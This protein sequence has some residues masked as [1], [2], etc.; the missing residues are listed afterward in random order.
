MAY[1]PYKPK[2]SGGGAT[3]TTAPKPS[4]GGYDPYAGVGSKSSGGSTSSGSSSGSSKQQPPSAALRNAIGAG[5]V[6]KVRRIAKKRGITGRDLKGLLAVTKFA[7]PDTS[8]LGRFSSDV[9][10]T[11]ENLPRG[12]AGTAKAAGMEALSLPRLVRDVSE[13]KNVSVDQVLGSIPGLGQAYGVSRGFIEEKPSDTNP[14][15][16]GIGASFRHTTDRITDP[17]QA[18]REYSQHPFS[19]AMEDAGNVAVAAGVGARAARLAGLEKTANFLETGSRT[20]DTV[21]QGPFLPVSPLARGANKVIGK[22]VGKIDD[23]ERLHNALAAMHQSRAAREAKAILSERVDRT[24]QA[25]NTYVKTYIK[26]VQKILPTQ[27][28]QDALYAVGKHWDQSLAVERRASPDTFDQYV[29]DHAK[30]YDNISVKAAHM[31]ADVFEGKAPKLAAKIDK[32]MPILVKASKEHEAAQ[33]ASGMNPEQLGYKPL[34]PVVEGAT[35]P[36]DAAAQAKAEV[37][38]QIRARADTAGARAGAVADAGAARLDRQREMTTIGEFG[39]PL[40]NVRRAE[41][42]IGGPITGRDINAERAVA[43]AGMSEAGRAAS[44]QTRADMLNTRANAAERGATR[45]FDKAASVRAQ[46]EASVEA[47]PARLRPV[48]E[49]NQAAISHLTGVENALRGQGLHD[50]AMLVGQAA[51]ELPST[52]AALEEAGIDAPHFIRTVAEPKRGPR[53]VMGSTTPVKEVRQRTGKGQATQSVLLQGKALAA[54]AGQVI[55]NETIAKLESSEFAKMAGEVLPGQTSMLRPPRLEEL[56]AAG[57]APLK[58]AEA[59]TSNTIVVPKEVKAVFDNYYKKAGPF[60]K[61]LEYAYD[62]LTRAFKI[63]VLPLSP[64]WQVGNAIGNT[65]MA[66]FGAGVGPVALSK[67]IIQSIAEYK[68]T[69]EFPGPERLRTHGAS[70]ESQEVM[71]GG[72]TVTKAPRAR[73]ALRK[74][75]PIRAGYGMNEFIDNLGRSAVYLSKKSKGYSDEMATKLTLRAMGDFQKL[76][77]FEKR[78]VRR[79]LPFYAW[80][81]HL[82]K[83]A[84]TMPIEHPLRT[85]FTL[86]LGNMFSTKEDWEGLLPGYLKGSVPFGP[87]SYIQTSSLFPFGNPLEG[88]SNIKGGLNPILKLLA[89]NVP[90]SPAQGVNFFTGKPYTR[91]PGTGRHNDTGQELPT[92]PSLLEQIKSISPQVRLLEQLQGKKDIARYETGDPV[93][94][95]DPKT[96]KRV[97]IPTPKDDLE[98]VL[99]RFGVNIKSKKDLQEFVDAIIARNVE[100]WKTAHPKKVVKQ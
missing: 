58:P 69:G 80:M 81:K 55:H 70:W 68:K 11:A 62:P 71:R 29:K 37:A 74:V 89:T 53:R 46:V 93:L 39:Q 97:T 35:A 16:G 44:A 95:R 9:T 51:A 38:A 60:E 17:K 28:G 76:S 94:L 73:G 48:V 100:N 25:E 57:Y 12:L 72:K 3:T 20:L 10:N 79:A 40:T 64:S 47:A 15:L 99:Q 26:P 66:T 32:A 82:T 90:G 6:V 88:F 85:A 8:F 65:F 27:D 78:V 24:G 23:T 61:S 41:G 1:D 22:A 21:A 30:V 83:L 19:T 91:P 36:L 54:H 52:L 50:Q 45:A 2:P 49:A 7:T 33:L 77:P 31:A 87:D 96:G 63:T 42:D 56:E 5:N 92:A 86:E 75:S 14:F 4:G 18:V 34:T 67:G 59:L 13:G 43:R 98:T 84:F